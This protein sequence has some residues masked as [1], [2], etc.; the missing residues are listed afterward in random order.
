M[1]DSLSHWLALREPIDAT[2]RSISL[3]RQVAAALPRD[4]PV[5]ILD[6][7]TGTGSNVRFLAPHFPA[8][9]HWLLVD[10]DRSVL[11][12]IPSRVPVAH[13]TRPLD[14]GARDAPEIFA[15]R[16][17]VTA[18]ALLDLVSEPFLDWLARRCR[19]HDAV[20]LFALTY[21]GSSTCSPAEPDDDWIC[22]LL[23]RHQQHCDK[24]FGPAAGP[25]A[26]TLAQQAF[27]TAGY[28]VRRE[29][30]DWR[31]APAAREL[32]SLLMQGWADAATELAPDESSMI[33]DWLARR[34][35][36]VE[37]GTSHVTVRHEDLAA[38]LS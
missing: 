1:T 23:N 26:V 7:G 36:H 4:G 34:R 33:G 13:E 32:Q 20:A 29:P 28:R 2:A 8:D 21:T 37:A 16:D 14:L 18:S 27:V 30:S 5:Q 25:D 3:T 6:L 10:K 17:L 19:E 22:A 9:Q 24:G 15:G 11:A 12:E 35:A 31:V 38:F